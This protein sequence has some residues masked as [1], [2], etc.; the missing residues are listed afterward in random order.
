MQPE[1]R[2]SFRGYVDA[3]IGMYESA[4]S[5]AAGLREPPDLSRARVEL[6]TRAMAL[7]LTPEGER[8]RMLILPSLTT[9]FD[10]AETERMARRIHP[11]LLIYAMLGV[12]VIAGALFSGYGLASGR[13]RNWMFTI[14]IAA[15][16]AIAM[17]VI[18]ELEFPRLGIVR[19][20]ASDQGLRDVRALIR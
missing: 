15:T 3:L 17:F 4:P 2:T 7:T 1:I 14:G 13:T 16:V 19:V 10:I 11:P 5:V 18:I 20:D 8:A 6:W 9:M 12:A